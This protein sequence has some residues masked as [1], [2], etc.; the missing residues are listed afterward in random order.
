M[1]GNFT[2]D[3]TNFVNH[4]RSNIDQVV[5]KTVLDIGTKLVMR[6]PV[7]DP[8]YWK[9]PAPPGYSGGHF[10]ANWQYGF[11]V[12][13]SGELPDIDKSGRVSISRIQSGTPVGT[14]AGAIHYIVN[15]LPY[16]E[17]LENGW[18]WHQAP[19]GI[20]KKVILEFPGIVNNAARDIN[21]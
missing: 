1:A 15:N 19:E 10:R 3:I 14:S 12:M 7:G 13:P 16:S 20:V 8:V 6:S 2:L 17:R 21:R 9:H 5:R 4:A 18:S 11:N